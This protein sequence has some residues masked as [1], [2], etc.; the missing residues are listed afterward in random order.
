MDRFE[1]SVE[2]AYLPAE[3]AT[4]P[5]DKTPSSY[6]VWVTDDPN[7]DEWRETLVKVSPRSEIIHRYLS[8]TRNAWRT[9]VSDPHAHHKS[10]HRKPDPDA[11]TANQT[12]PSTANPGE[13]DA[14]EAP[15]AEQPPVADAATDVSTDNLTETEE[16]RN[17]TT[18]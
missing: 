1:I 2:L 12:V 15:A 17:D 5:P 11:G 6:R 18:S 3:D 7:L 4:F 13:P 16:E 10:H 14:Q 9:P 8:E